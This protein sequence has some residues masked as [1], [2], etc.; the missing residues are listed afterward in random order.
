M[1]DLNLQ[2]FRIT[3]NAKVFGMNSK[4]ITQIIIE[5][6]LTNEKGLVSD[7][8]MNLM[9]DH[10]HKFYDRYLEAWIL[11][12]EIAMQRISVGTMPE[13]NIKHSDITQNYFLPNYFNHK[14]GG[15]NYNFTEMVETQTS[16]NDACFNFLLK[17]G[18]FLLQKSSRQMADILFFIINNHDDDGKY[19]SFTIDNNIDHIKLINFAKKTLYDN[20]PVKL[21]IENIANENVWNK[22]IH[23]IR[24]NWRYIDKQEFAEA[25]GIEGPFKKLKLFFKVLPVKIF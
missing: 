19:Q 4:E 23:Y 3:Q 22:H 7:K 1:K 21:V 8:F 20:L 12:S 25:I 6:V 9:A 5:K 18:N 2:I 16:F 15:R 11:F 17:Q 13:A 24:K 14:K 10:L